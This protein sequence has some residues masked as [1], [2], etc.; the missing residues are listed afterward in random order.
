MA[1]RIFI[2]T[3]DPIYLM[4]QTSLVF[5]AV[6][7]LSLCSHTGAATE[8]TLDRLI[9]GLSAEN[10]QDRFAPQMELQDLAAKACRPGAESEREELA[11]AL[12]TKVTDAT[13]R[14]PARVWMVRQLEICGG[15]ES[16]DAL[17]QLLSGPDREL[18]ETARRALEKNPTTSAGRVLLAALEKDD[19]PDWQIGII[20]SL[21][22][23]KE[24]RAVELIAVTLDRQEAQTSFVAAQALGR[25]ATTAAVKALWKSYG[26]NQADA[27]AGLLVAAEELL[28]DGHKGDAKKILERLHRESKTATIQSSALILLAKAD[29]KGSRKLIP[30]ALSSAHPKLRTAAR[31]AAQIAFGPDLQSAL[32]EMFSKLSPEGKIVIMEAFDRSAERLVIDACSDPNESVRFA[33][34]ETLGRIGGESSVSL[35]LDIA[36]AGTPPGALK[37]TTALARLPGS[38]TDT[39]LLRQV[40]SGNP[41]VRATA[42]RGLADRNYYASLPVLI[43]CAA[44]PEP[45]ISSAALLAVGKLGADSELEELLRLTVTRGGEA[46]ESAL[47]RVVLR[48]T[49]KN[50]AARKLVSATTTAAPDRLG[51]LY[52][53]LALLDAKE[54][55]D[56]LNRA[57]RSNDDEVREPAVRALAGSP[58][59][60]AIEP[61]LNVAAGSTV[62]K[63]H[64]ALLLQAVA[65]LVRASDEVPP[66]RR[67]K[68]SLSALKAAQRSEE[69]TLALSALASVTDPAAA[70]AIQ[71]FLR[72]PIL[73][74]DA[75]LAAVTLA[76]RLSRSHK[77]S[78]R[79]LA[80]AIKQAGLPED[81]TR[82]ADAI[83]RQ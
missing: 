54:A 8:S 9:P 47:E 20:H 22:Q 30:T 46:A 16:V 28:S 63:V 43:K 51:V 71:P 24:G 23:R 49:D 67:I 42:I 35:L 1:N 39:A 83:L 70:M 69:Q 3:C 13:V 18:A 6:L 17:A 50:A 81:V 65:R 55:M 4:K 58:H 10:P 48:T 74:Y 33:A 76:E 66:E 45:A 19:S 5:A 61:I 53:N 11:K 82:K 36:A 44:D 34:I 79:D 77:A 29:P 78:A 38:G 41:K 56:A 59:F 32:L 52:G 64:N 25:I 21:G 14:Q 72:D 15:K 75:G 2:P 62:K 40:S 7:L 80:R 60:S 31:D 68:A 37:A 73:K 27:A 26:V 57:A 12:A